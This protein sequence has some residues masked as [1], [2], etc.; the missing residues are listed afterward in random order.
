M[1]YFGAK[2]SVTFQNSHVTARFCWKFCSKKIAELNLLLDILF[3]IKKNPNKIYTF[4]SGFDKKG[5]KILC[6]ML[7]LGANFTIT[8]KNCLFCCVFCTKILQTNFFYKF[9]CKILGGF[10]NFANF[11]CQKFL[12]I[13]FFARILCLNLLR[14]FSKRFEAKINRQFGEIFAAFGCFAKFL[15]K[16]LQFLEVLRSLWL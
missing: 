3:A 12:R 7:G 1:V 15:L 13:I 16:F 14:I 6:K 11:L 8:N 4:G 10:T 9:L 2:W 5:Y